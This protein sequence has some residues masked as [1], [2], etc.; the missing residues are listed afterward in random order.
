[1]AIAKHWELFFLLYLHTDVKT[2][3]LEKL[4]TGQSK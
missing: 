3:K 4:E 1:M 2:G